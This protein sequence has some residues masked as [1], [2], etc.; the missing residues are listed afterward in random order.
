MNRDILEGKWKQFRGEIK[1]TWG[2][3][4]DDELDQIGGRYDKL[5]GK[6]QERYGYSREEAEEEL[7]RFLEDR[8]GW[9]REEPFSL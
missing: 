1:E 2:E 4:T 7:D 9:Q 8:A 6:L 3:L 5:V